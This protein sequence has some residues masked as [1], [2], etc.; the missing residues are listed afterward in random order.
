MTPAPIPG[1]EFKPRGAAPFLLA[2]FVL[3]TLIVCMPV[4]FG[5]HERANNDKIRAALVAEDRLAN[6][7]SSA[8]QAENGMRGYMIT[9]NTISLR[10][11]NAALA[12]LP[13]QLAA[14]DGS[15]GGSYGP[16]IATIHRLV[17]DKTIE[18]QDTLVIYQS[19]HGQAAAAKIN[20]DLNLGTMVG[21]RSLVQV[22][23]DIEAARIADGE[24]Q[25]AR[26]AHVLESA[27]SFAILL[28]LLMAWFA[29]RENAAQTR[30]LQAAEGALLR[31]NEILEHKVA[32]RTATLAASEAQFRTLAEAMPGL[33]YMTD[34]DGQTIYVN[35]QA[36][37][38]T[39]LPAQAAMGYGW[40]ECIH[41]DDLPACVAD[42]EMSVA[43]GVPYEIEFRLRRRDGKYRWFLDRAAPV[44]DAGQHITGWIGSSTDIEDR[45]QAEAA[46]ANDNALLE[47][48][49]AERSLQ[50]DRI[51]KLST[52]ILAVADFDGRFVSVSPAWEQI[53]FL[54]VEAALGGNYFDFLHPEHV[55]AALVDFAKLKQGTAIYC[56][57]RYKRA[58]GTWCWLAWRAVPM[59]QEQL[60]YA[61]ARDITAAREREEQL[62]Q[63]QKMEVVGQ[64]TGGVAHDFNNLLTIIMGSLEMLQRGLNG[65]EPKLQRRVDAAL[66]GAR[67]AA[68]LTQRL[69]AF[70]RRQPLAPTALEVNRLLAGMSDMLHRTL[71]EMI[72]VEFVSAAGLWPAL[73]DA[74]QLEN[75]ILNLAVNARDAMPQ[76]GRLTIETQNTYLDEDYTASRPD[77]LPG[78]YVLV[79]VTDTGSGMS[80]EVQQKVFEPFFTTKPQGEGTGLGLAQ[81]YG[82]IKQSGGHV[83]IYSE[84]GQGT[85]VKLYLPRRRG[86]ESAAEPSDVAPVGAVRGRAETILLVEDEEGVRQFSAE[87]MEE[88]G[89][90]VFTAATGE[91][92]LRVFHAQPGIRLVF[93]DVVLG[94]GMNGRQLANAIIAQKPETLVLFTTGY[95]RNAI[96]H[97]GRLDDGIHFLGKPFTATALAQKLAS[98]LESQKVF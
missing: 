81:V 89:Y 73:A 57:N 37:A 70:S 94:G 36:C 20:D 14:L 85:S 50:L 75:A 6:I 68:A 61:V 63:S 65:S 44:R 15:F 97:H 38:Y 28:T 80:P 67:R 19:G 59:L 30:Q 25:V 35:P 95:T 5:A 22:M 96:I 39:G 60:I 83:S 11:Y 12:A 74:N 1:T 84:L 4:L 48:R 98:M 46:M 66:E 32:E 18:L 56:E 29:I 79:A 47:S 92:G 10:T 7:L 72:Q 93:T 86:V 62:R 24:A 23:H 3:L 26:D 64:L 17:Q 58:D 41:P 16:E 9:G 87:V 54:P 33:V 51:F 34:A 76:G 13:R 40:T 77:L 82:F 91:E 31:A 2:G 43:S 52:D 42:W 53:T 90:R 71:G 27:T 8:R 88:L 69:L 45:K 49:V 55:E 21:L 78:Q